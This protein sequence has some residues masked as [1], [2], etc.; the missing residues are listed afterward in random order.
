MTLVPEFQS[1]Q[2]S[3]MNVNNFHVAMFIHCLGWEVLVMFCLLAQCDV[4]NV[5]YSQHRIYSPKTVCYFF[6]ETQ[7][8]PFFGVFF[9]TLK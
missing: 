5:A 1:K 9:C 4:M 6:H 8:V 2:K 3:G 7:S